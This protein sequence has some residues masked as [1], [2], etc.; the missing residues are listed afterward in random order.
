MEAERLRSGATQTA[1]VAPTP[2]LVVDPPVREP[3]PAAARIGVPRLTPKAVVRKRS[4][5]SGGSVA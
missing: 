2:F 1:S 3:Q 5:P 4:A